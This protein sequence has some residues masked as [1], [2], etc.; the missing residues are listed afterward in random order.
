MEHCWWQSASVKRGIELIPTFYR[1]FIPMP[2]KMFDQMIIAFPLLPPSNL[3]NFVFESPR[4]A[5]ELFVVHLNSVIAH[6]EDGHVGMVF[7][8]VHI[9]P[10]FLKG[11]S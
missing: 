9:L 4:A 7:S 3:S 1:F 10:I 2:Y 11:V 6:H 5:A 8:G